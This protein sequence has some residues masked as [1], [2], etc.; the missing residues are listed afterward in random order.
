[1]FVVLK[2]N[3]VRRIYMRRLIFLGIFLFSLT[4]VMG[5]SID[6]SVISPSGN[7]YESS[8]GT[9]SWTL[10]EMATETYTQD[11]L[12]LTQGFHQSYLNVSSLEDN[13]MILSK[14]SVY[15]NP[16]SQFIRVEIEKP[17]GAYSISITNDAGQM[18]LNARLEEN[19]TTKQL[20]LS[21]FADGLYIITIT[22]LKS[23]EMD[24]YKIIKN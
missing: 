19:E 7:N 22:T 18:M 9:I 12:V 8:F 11:N 10:G 15:P 6:R 23:K 3:H 5:Q 2:I 20:D 21:G 13:R 14:V 24:S 16:T 1:M 17:N 4:H